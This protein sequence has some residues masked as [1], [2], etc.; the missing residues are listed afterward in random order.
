MYDNEEARS[1][2]FLVFEDLSNVTKADILSKSN[3]TIENEDLIK[4]E[5]CLQRL[6]SG[7]PV[8]YI[9]GSAYFL[10]R[11]FFVNDQVLIPRQE[12]EELVQWILHSREERNSILDIG[13]GTGIIPISLMLADGS[14]SATGWDISNA[15]LA[16]A[17]K[18]S[19]KFQVDVDFLSVDVL[20]PLEIK[21][22]YDIIISNPPYITESE[23]TGMPLNVLEFEPE[24]ALFVPNNDPLL[25]YRRIS[26]IAKESLEN[27]GLLFFEINERFGRE[28][29]ELLE[30]SGF[31]KIE[32]REDLNGKDRMIRAE[33][34]Q[35]N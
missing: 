4:L 33:I 1:I 24:I 16:I 3:L 21:K 10:G 8:Q 5:N 17:K 25:F 7:E 6:L 11:R 32:L 29:Y 26:K 9:L 20:Q 19:Q 12:T 13:T 34:N 23:K 35:G 18:N 31:S 30:E 14:I 15:S 2:S 27:G 28:V 22:K